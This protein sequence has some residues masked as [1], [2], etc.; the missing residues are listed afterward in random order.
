MKLRGL[1][2]VRAGFVFA[3]AAYNIIRLPKLLARKAA[4]LKAQLCLAA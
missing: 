1:D 2:K 4:P 3:V